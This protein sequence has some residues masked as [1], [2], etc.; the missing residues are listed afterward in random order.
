MY[1]KSCVIPSNKEFHLVGH[2]YLSEQPNIVCIISEDF[3]L[4]DKFQSALHLPIT[5]WL[6]LE[7]GVPFRILLKSVVAI[8]LNVWL[9]QRKWWGKKIVVSRLLISSISICSNNGP[10]VLSSSIFSCSSAHLKYFN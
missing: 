5:E 8:R 9:A 3:G 10:S 1:F 6:S 2:G 7:A 4:R